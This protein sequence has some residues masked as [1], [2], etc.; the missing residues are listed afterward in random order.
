MSSS[1]KAS[2]CTIQLHCFQKCLCESKYR[3]RACHIARESVLV[4]MF[5]YLSYSP[6]SFQIPQYY[7]VFNYFSQCMLQ[8]FF[9]YFSAVP[10]RF[11]YLQSACFKDIVFKMFSV[12]RNRL[13]TVR[14]Q[15]LEILFSKT[16]SAFPNRFKQ[17]ENEWFRYIIFKNISVV[18]NRFKYVRIHVLETLV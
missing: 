1:I 7:I 16:C 17:C 13:N 2:E 9:I 4:F 10:N 6:K 18:L 8:M 14:M 12:V 3:I 5:S 15:A 11:K